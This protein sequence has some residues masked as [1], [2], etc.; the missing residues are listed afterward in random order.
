MGKSGAGKTSMRSIIFANFVARD[1]RRLGATMDVEQ[2]HVRLL[3]NLV[4]NLWDCGAHDEFMK[5]YLTSQRAQ[6]FRGVQVLIYVFDVESREWEKDL[7][8][9]ENTVA[10]MVENSKDA[11]VFCLIHKMDLVNKDQRHQVFSQ[12]INELRQRANTLNIT[13][14]ATSIW[15][16]TL[17]QAWS[18]IVYSIIPNV[19]VL[20][21]HLERFCH[22]CGAEEVILFE[23]S[24]FLVISHT[25]PG[26]FNQLIPDNNRFEKVS[27][28]IKQFKLSCLKNQAQFQNMEVRCNSLSAF[29]DIFT[30]NT[31]IMVV[32]SNPNIQ[33]S[34][35][36]NNIALARKHFEKV[37]KGQL[38]A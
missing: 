25:T 10:A 35:T 18:A 8:D 27:N 2:S 30:P 21:T 12:A 32:V 31:Y 13:Y 1:T 28:M 17:Y 24:T 14:Y 26:N 33:P 38:E 16:E 20:E 19:K 4:L 7:A 23:R 6:I 37:E 15:D 11:N 5:S 22:I 29:V 36:M 3:G 9:F 34:A